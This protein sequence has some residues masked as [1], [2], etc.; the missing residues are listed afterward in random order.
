M[1]IREG[2][3]WYR[4]ELDRELANYRKTGNDRHY[5]RIV[6]ILRLLIYRSIVNKFSTKYYRYDIAEYISQEVFKP[7]SNHNCLFYT[8]LKKYDVSYGL[9]FFSYIYHLILLR[10]PTYLT[11]FFRDVLNH[12]SH[13][14]P[15]DDYVKNNNEFTFIKG[16]DVAVAVVDNVDEIERNDDILKYILYKFNLEHST[17]FDVFVTIFILRP[18]FTMENF[19][20]VLGVNFRS[21]STQKYRALEKLKVIFYQ[22]FLED[23][24]TNADF[25]RMITQDNLFFDNS[26]LSTFKGKTYDIALDMIVKR[27]SLEKLCDKYL[28]EFNKDKFYY[29]IKKIIS[30]LTKRIRKNLIVELKGDVFDERCC[31]I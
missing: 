19:G 12:A 30:K 8:A 14:I 26:Y 13:I 27:Y 1:K 15:I 10:L 25:Y 28:K 5:H 21:L 22:Y 3:Q 9:P 31:H 18:D 2:F 6:N 29:T 23:D 16:N 4:N 11:Y 24:F 20:D 7:T 17:Y